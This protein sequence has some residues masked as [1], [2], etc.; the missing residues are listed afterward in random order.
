MLAPE[1]LDAARLEDAVGEPVRDAKILVVSPALQSSPLAFWMSDSDG[2]ISDA[3]ETADATESALGEAGL[4][5]TAVTGESEPL[6]ALQD[7][8]ATFQ[9][10]R[11]VVFVHDDDEQKYRE[12][13]VVGEAERRFG[14]PVTQAR[15]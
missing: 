14:V 10:D 5:A 4:Q 6:L 7:A 8:L 12:D 3:Q 1:T 11:I 13:D 2:A 15:I 9:A